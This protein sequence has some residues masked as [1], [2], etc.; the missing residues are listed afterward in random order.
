MTTC[1]RSGR[2]LSARGR[3]SARSIGRARSASSTSGSRRA[4]I[5]V[6]HGQTRK[7][8]VVIACLGYSRAGAGALVFSKQTPDL[9]VGHPALSVVAGGAAAD[10]GLGPPVRAAR[11]RRA[12]DQ[13]VRRVLRPAARRLVL[14][15]AARSAGQG[16]RRA[17]AGLRRAQLRA[18]PGVR[19]RARLP[20]AARR[21]VRAP[22]ER[23]ACTRRCA[24]G[25]STG[26]SRSAR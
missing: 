11:R 14:L 6:G 10:A 25:R 26:W 16:R 1:A 2:C 19:Q 22:R 7:G 24:A 12:P 17:P 20:A 13:G 5:P 3:F 18:R 15:R 4:E 23:P 9:L 8:W 21:L